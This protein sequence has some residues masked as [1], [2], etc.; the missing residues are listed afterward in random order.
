[1]S[2]PFT[3]HNYGQQVIVRGSFGWDGFPADAYTNRFKFTIVMC[4]LPLV[5]SLQMAYSPLLLIS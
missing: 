1:M 2:S 3:F 4:L 5:F